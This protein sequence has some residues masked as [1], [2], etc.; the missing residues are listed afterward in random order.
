M[1]YAV[2]QPRTLCLDDVCESFLSVDVGS[3]ATLQIDSAT[4]DRN[5]KLLL[6]FSFLLCYTP[7]HIAISVIFYEIVMLTYENKAHNRAKLNFLQ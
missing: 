7:H 2:I 4:I 1:I 3:N 5:Y 6:Q